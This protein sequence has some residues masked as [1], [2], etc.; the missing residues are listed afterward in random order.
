MHHV[1]NL[2][3]QPFAMI[4]NG[5][6]TIELRLFDE[7]R[8]RIRVGDSIT[9]VNTQNPS[10]TVDVSV[11]RLHLFPSFQELYKHLPLQKCGYRDA[12]IPFASPS[13]MNAYYSAEQQQRCGVVGIEIKTIS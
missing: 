11:I 5:T 4:A 2:H 9:F 1:M 12:D 3:P 10:E 6:K 7:K 8:R 13:D